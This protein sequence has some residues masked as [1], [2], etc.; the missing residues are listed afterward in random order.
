MH[1]SYEGESMG[2]CGGTCFDHLLRAAASSMCLGCHGPGTSD[3][4]YD[5]IKV[6]STD[7]LSPIKGGVGAG[8]GDFAFL[9]EDNLNDGHG[10]AILGERGGHNVDAPAFGIDPDTTLTESPG[11]TYP[12]SELSCVSCHEPHGGPQFRFLH[13]SASADP[14]AAFSGVSAP[15]VVAISVH[16]TEANN[17]HNAYKSGMSEWCSA[18][19]GDFHSEAGVG[20]VHPTRTISSGIATNYNSYDGTDQPSSATPYLALVPVEWNNASNTTDLVG[21]ITGTAKVM[22]LTCHRAHASTGPSSGRWDFN[23]TTWEDEG[24]GGSWVIPN[25]YAATAG[26]G[27]RSL[28]NKCH[29]QD[30]GDL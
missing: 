9:L 29:I 19:H 18:C 16:D 4:A 10:G 7:P 26:I 13:H 6:M 27:Q 3:P 28:C 22:C 30:E 23:I 5:S 8:G 15:T 1:D 2:G 11:G 24:H 17:N 20:L 14:P 21:N 12:S 25:P